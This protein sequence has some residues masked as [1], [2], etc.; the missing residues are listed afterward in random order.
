[1][2]DFDALL[3]PP[4]SRH[5][6]GPNAIGQDLLAQIPGGMY[7]SML[8][9]VCVGFISTGIAA[10]V[11]SIS[12]YFGGWRDRVLMWVVDL[13]LVVPSF[14]L[15]AIVSPRT[16]SSANIILLVLLLR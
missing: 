15:I 7:K 11:E 8:I 14:I 1:D 13:L 16:K 6:L 5:W 10:T 9:G 2:L 4:N 3:Q 12:G